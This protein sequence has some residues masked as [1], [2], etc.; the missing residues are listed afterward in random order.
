[1]L[2]LRLRYSPLPFL[3]R[4]K[5]S[6]RWLA[7]GDLQ[8]RPSLRVLMRMGSRDLQFEGRPC[9]VCGPKHTTPQS[10]LLQ[11]CRLVEKIGFRK[12]LALPLVFRGP[13]RTK[14]KRC[15]WYE[16]FEEGL[17]K[18]GCV[19]SQAACTLGHIPLCRERPGPQT[20][21]T[22]L[23][24]TQARRAD[25]RQVGRRQNQI[26]RM[27]MQCIEDRKLT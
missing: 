15:S 16:A 11:F 12:T 25:L 17:Q 1:M 20:K 26:K 19:L 5:A 23:S 2:S 22:L 8:A 3:I 14:G 13:Q 18:S 7:S 27:M 4:T 10:T 9:T 21:E 6:Q 24:L